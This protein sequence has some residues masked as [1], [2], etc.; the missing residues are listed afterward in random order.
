MKKFICALLILVMIS[1]PVM[2]MTSEQ[3]EK[4]AKIIHTSALGAAGSATVLAQAPGADNVAL[5]LIIGGMVWQLAEV[6]N[7]SLSETIAEIG[8][9]IL[10][11]F[12]GTIAARTTSQWAL[13]WIPGLGN[14]FNAATMA[15]LVEYIGWTTA[16]NFDKYGA[17]WYKK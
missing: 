6:F 13:G 10:I 17:D 3:E 12:A 4:C 9:I 15:A 1:S 11:Y 2:A 5:V 16:E 8:K 14:A 7:I